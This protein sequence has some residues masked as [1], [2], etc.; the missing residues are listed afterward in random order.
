MIQTRL[1]I[2]SII[3]C[4][5]I[6]RP[7]T[8][9]SQS[10]EYIY[11]TPEDELIYD[12]TSDSSGNFYLVGQ[13]GTFNPN[14]LFASYDALIIKMNSFGDTLKTLRIPA[15]NSWKSLSG[16]YI[17]NDTLFI[18]SGMVKNLSGDF[19]IYFV[20]F[21]QNL[22]ILLETSFGNS[23][24]NEII[25]SDKRAKNG[26]FLVTGKASDLNDNQ[27]FYSRF[28]ANG[29]SLSY[30]Q[31]GLPANPSEVA[32]DILELHDTTGYI[33][34][35]FGWPSQNFEIH[36]EL[37][38]INNTGI[39][40]TVVEVYRS[41]FY[42]NAEW[43]SDS[44]FITNGI[45][46]DPF[47]ISNNIQET[48]IRK[49]NLDLVIQDSLMTGKFDTTEAWA[50]DGISFVDTSN[51]FIGACSNW[52][53]SYFGT[54]PSY[55]AL[56]KLNSN[57]AIKWEKYYSYNDDYLALL[58][59]LAIPDDGVILAGTKYN[60][61]LSNGY[62]RD[63]YIIKLD[64]SGNFLTSTIEYPNIFISDFIVYP[65]PIT[66]VLNIVQSAE[67]KL[68]SIVVYNTLGKLILTK[69]LL[70]AKSEINLNSLISGVYYYTLIGRSGKKING[71]FIK[72]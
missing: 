59:V 7:V 8:V 52:Q 47:T 43:I 64:S 35:S 18:G 72:L 48:S 28:N 53:G 58:K 41:F 44:V 69:S 16:I 65:N 24:V 17:I 63:I 1:A 56:L 55:F 9:Q 27:I 62:E 66:D 61:L 13:I 4:Y 45:T 36:N 14:F 33:L 50:V 34:C 70:N 39:V 60:S 46:Y 31:F 21:D 29:D 19:Q 68:T 22:N 11:S 40:D 37:L 51:I 32:Y 3:I 25:Y 15:I 38:R 20:K 71:K 42:L 54:D 10:F 30:Y 67:S 57:L 6:L 2:I 5:Y 23:Q 26:E 49:F 12:I